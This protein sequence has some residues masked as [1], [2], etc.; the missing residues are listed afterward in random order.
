MNGSPQ[1]DLL[2]RFLKTVCTKPKETQVRLDGRT[3]VIS[4]LASDAGRVL[5]SRAEVYNALRRII[6]HSGVYE[7]HPRLRTPVIGA[8]SRIQFPV[9]QNWDRGEMCSF[10][11]SLRAC[12]S[13]HGLHGTGYWPNECI[14]Y[15]APD[16]PDRMIKDQMLVLNVFGLALG[17]PVIS[18]ID[19]PSF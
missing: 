17:V 19:E 14:A 7:L 5:G 9:N 18:K 4:C 2:E 13:P 12:A 1:H 3:F 8:R 16:C 10:A 15:F 11:M 6:G